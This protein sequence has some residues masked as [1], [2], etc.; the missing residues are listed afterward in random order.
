MR[1]TEY[2]SKLSGL[3]MKKDKIVKLKLNDKLYSYRSLIGIFTYV[4][5]GVRNYKD[6]VFY[7][8]ECE[9]CKGHDRCRLLVSRVDNMD[10]FKYVSMVDEDEEDEQYYLHSTD[11]FFMSKNECKKAAYEAVKARKEE[12]IEQMKKDLKRAED[13]LNEIKAYYRWLCIVLNVN[14]GVY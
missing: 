6:S 1:R 8:V 10:R 5:L 11:E 13:S 9:E 4:V 3:N 7:E 12:E 14:S 2:S